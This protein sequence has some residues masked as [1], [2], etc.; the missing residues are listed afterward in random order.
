MSWI[1]EVEMARSIHDSRTSQSIEGRRD[2]PDFEMLD[3]R[4]VCV[5]IDHLQYLFSKG[6]SVL[7]SSKPKSVP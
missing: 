3:A 2:F 7:N 5:E 6:V 4:N 1:N